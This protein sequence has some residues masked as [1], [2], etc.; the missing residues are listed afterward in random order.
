MWKGSLRG[1]VVLSEDEDG[2]G[3]VMLPRLSHSLA[4]AI[5]SKGRDRWT[6]E[7]DWSEMNVDNRLE[8]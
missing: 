6:D 2:F 3:L 4:M 8:S 7:Q 5:I 1:G